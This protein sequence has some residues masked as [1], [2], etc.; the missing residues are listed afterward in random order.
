ME[1]TIKEIEDLADNIEFS[2]EP[3][4]EIKSKE[5]ESSLAKLEEEKER[6]SV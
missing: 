1:N 4:A 6:N 5:R 3:A 2:P